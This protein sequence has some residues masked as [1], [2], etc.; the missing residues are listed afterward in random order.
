MPYNR[1]GLMFYAPATK[2]VVEGA[3]VIELGIPG[4]AVK[5]AAPAFGTGP[6]FVSGVVNPAL[7]TIAI[8]E[9][10]VII[11]KG[12]VEVSAGALGTPA[13][14][15]PVYIVSATNALSATSNSGANPK[16]GRVVEIPGGTRGPA[17][18]RVRI[19]L[20]HKATF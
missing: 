8:T 2:T 1:P 18:G 17:T 10:F 15:D 20:D 3:P 6:A 4:V 19:D 13:K 16:Y 9:P 11:S 5:Q 7:V 12:I 14:G